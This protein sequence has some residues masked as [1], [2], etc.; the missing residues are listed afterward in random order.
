MKIP[1]K[2]YLFKSL[3]DNIT[4]FGSIKNTYPRRFEGE[5]IYYLQNTLVPE[6]LVFAI[7]TGK[8]EHSIIGDWSNSWDN[9]LFTIINE[10]INTKPAQ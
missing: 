5:R 6:S 1:T 2:T 3:G 8:A 9:N 7:K 4:H 10:D